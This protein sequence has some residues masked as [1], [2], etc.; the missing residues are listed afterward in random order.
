MNERKEKKSE[1]RRIKKTENRTT[2][3][4]FEAS[5]M[6]ASSLPITGCIIPS[7]PRQSFLTQLSSSSSSSSSIFQWVPFHFTQFHISL[8][9]LISLL[10]FLSKRF[11]FSFWV[12]VFRK[13]WLHY[14]VFGMIEGKVIHSLVLIKF[15]LSYALLVEI[16][17]W[18]WETPIHAYN[19]IC[20]SCI[21]YFYWKHCCN[22]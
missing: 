9:Y 13:N 6:A 11:Y 18:I 7:T 12:F 17:F 1:R 2:G 8:Y 3:L 5:I 15:A 20:N 10:Q 21:L 16:I 22:L 4:N 19:T 14:L